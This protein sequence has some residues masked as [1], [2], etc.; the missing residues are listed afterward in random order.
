[1][2]GDGVLDV[3]VSV[4]AYDG[5]HIYAL[6]G[7]TG[8]TLPG[9]PIALPDGGEV[10]GAIIL[11][12]LHNYASLSP[13][14]PLTPS[15]YSDPYAPQWTTRSQGHAP[16]A[17]PSM[18]SEILKEEEPEP[19]PEAA[20]GA[21]EEEEEAGERRRRLDNLDPL[22]H[23]PRVRSAPL[24]AETKPF[25]E[26]AKKKWPKGNSLH[27][28]VPSFDG[29]L[30]IFDGTQSC[31][32]RIDLGDHIFSTPLVDDVTGDGNLDIVVGTVNGHL[33]VLETQ[34]LPPPP[35]PPHLTIPSLR[36]RTIPSTP[37]L[38]SPST[39]AM[40]SLMAR[41]ASPFL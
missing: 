29:H 12:D 4:S 22:S 16:A 30:Y 20:A 28:L 24:F 31:A 7:D 15:K 18:L 32:E 23:K 27:L 26:E 40:S 33:H 13:A 14:T 5:Y 41:S 38:L 17:S 21:A 6:R 35:S 25:S 19:V 37:G 3:V 1:V 8:E 9:Y 36:S 34:V 39:A 10:S 2:D 11:V